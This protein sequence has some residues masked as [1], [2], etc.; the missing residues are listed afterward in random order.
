MNQQNTKPSLAVAL[1]VKNEAKHLAACLDSVKDWVDEI[2][3]LDSGS[4]DTTEAIAH[5]YTDKFFVSNDWPGF[6]LQR[7]R[8]Q[9]YVESDYILW[10]D[11]DERV[12]PELR[13][14]IQQAVASNHINTVY[15]VN[16]L[17]TAFGKFI[18]HSGWHPDWIS[19]LHRRNETQYN[20]VKVHESIVIPANGKVEKLTGNLEHYTFEDFF[21]FQRKQQKYAE[22]WAEEK[23]LKG[24]KSSIASAVIHSMFS[25]I[26]TYILKAGF[27]DGKH[28]FIIACINAQY[29]LNK[30]LGLHL[31]HK[32]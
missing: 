13:Q 12:T 22:L 14:S 29:V 8:A 26:R 28:G 7:Q 27:L 19:R 16:R 6:G 10:L 1:I 2:V 9:Q 5:Q 21:E 15:Q 3:I 23:F 20:D 30:Y 25:F 4:S 11:A 24:K 18:R 17:S 31:K 32:K